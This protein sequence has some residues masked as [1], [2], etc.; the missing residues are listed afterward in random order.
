MIAVSVSN[1]WGVGFHVYAAVV[2]AVVVTVEWWLERR[3]DRSR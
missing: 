1:W 2:V 3:E